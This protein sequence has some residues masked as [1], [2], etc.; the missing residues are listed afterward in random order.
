MR[1]KNPECGKRIEE[2]KSAKRCYCDD[3]CKNRAAY[4]RRKENWQEVDEL[5][6]VLKANYKILLKLRDL[7]LGPISMQTLQS[8]GFEFTETHKDIMTDD[9]GRKK[10]ISRL[11]DIHFDIENKHLI[12]IE[13]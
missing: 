1:C 3:R 4:I 10:I 9:K 8:H 11:Y 7:N 12:F 6:K 5:N 2:R 13:Y